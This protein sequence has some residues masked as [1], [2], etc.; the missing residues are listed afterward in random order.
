MPRLIAKRAAMPAQATFDGQVIARWQETE[1]TEQ[2]SYQVPHISV[3]DGHQAWTFAGSWPYDQV[4]LGDHVRITVNPRS[5]ALV[6]L[7]VTGP[8]RGIS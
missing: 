7:T 4:T 5:C 3:D 2:A 8:G 6:A 1:N